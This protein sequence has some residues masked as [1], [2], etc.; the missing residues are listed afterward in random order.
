MPAKAS[1]TP[2]R[3]LSLPLKASAAPSLRAMSRGMAECLPSRSSEG[4]T[5][6]RRHAGHLRRALWRTREGRRATPEPTRGPRD[7]PDRHQYIQH[8]RRTPCQRSWKQK[9]LQACAGR[10]CRPSDRRLQGSPCRRRGVTVWRRILLSSVGRR[11]GRTRG[12]RIRGLLQ[13]LGWQ[14]HLVGVQGSSGGKARCRSKWTA[15]AAHHS[16]SMAKVVGRPPP[17][18]MS[19]LRQRHDDQRRR[20]PTV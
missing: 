2:W 11:R 12:R 7:R 18:A 6:N 8:T 10:P 1:R 16:S 13:R 9:S 4:H 17:G 14:S 19:P 3:R 5:R 20:A 15:A